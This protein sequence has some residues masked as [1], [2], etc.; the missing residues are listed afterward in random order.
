MGATSA[1]TEFLSLVGGASIVTSAALKCSNPTRSFFVFTSEMNCVA[2]VLENFNLVP[3][4]PENVS[5]MLRL[6]SRRTIMAT[7]RSS[8]HVEPRTVNSA[9]AT[10][11]LY[12]AEICVSPCDSPV[13]LPE[14]APTRAMFGS[15]LVK[16]LCEVTS[17]SWPRDTRTARNCTDPSGQAS[18]PAG[19]MMSMGAVG[20]RSGFAILKASSWQ[21]GSG[22]GTTFTQSLVAMFPKFI[23]DSLL[24]T[25]QTAR[26]GNASGPR[27]AP[28]AA[29]S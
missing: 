4:A 15:P 9:L 19:L 8:Q 28:A 22:G 16:M 25:S 1:A 6:V 12:V 11:P 26:H 23:R 13:A 29:R 10:S 17:V 21:R 5:D 7:W 18:A 14:V 24:R 2:A 3:C 27:H 20:H